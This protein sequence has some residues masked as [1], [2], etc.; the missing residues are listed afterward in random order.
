MTRL[1]VERCGPSSSVQDGGRT[2]WQR[3]GLSTS[4]ALDPLALATANALVGNAPAAPALELL[5]YGIRLRAL[6]GDARLA[7]AGA[8]FPLTIG[9]RPV[10]GHTSFVLG[11]GEV[12]EI[13]HSSAGVCA[14]VAI[15]GGL[16]VPLALGSASFHARAEVGNLDGRPLMPGD[17]LPVGR[18][19]SARAELAAPALSVGSEAP[20]HVVLGPQSDYFSDATIAAFLAA[21]FTVTADC[22]RMGY[23]LSGPVVMAREASSIISD[24]VVSGSIQ[25]PGSGQ[26]I[27]LLADR[28]TTGGYPK[29]ATV[30]TPDLR[31]IANRRPGERI[32]FVAVS[33]EEAQR[34]FSAWRAEL[35]NIPLRLRPARERL[36]SLH[37][38]NLAG[39]AVSAADPSTW[40]WPRE[41][42]AR[43][44]G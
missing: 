1:L 30:I 4:G 6:D 9:D 20:I 23:R 25:V 21:S 40:A 31:L 3:F 37:E 32:S 26:P 33:I 41:D 2:G 38:H 8:D 22:D 10:P 36:D 18:A 42:A 5:Q 43:A 35:A 15:E 29:I 19:A 44:L 27:V 28:Q 39:G 24:G 12:L 34:L 13:G 14:A 11:A 7:L 16:A 17:Q